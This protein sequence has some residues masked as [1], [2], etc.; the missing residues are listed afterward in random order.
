MQ[1]NKASLLLHPFFVG[2]LAVLL[3]NDCWGKYAFPGLLTG[4]LSDFVGLIVLP[5]FC[6][7]LFPSLSKK[8]I[9]L[10]VALFFIWFKSPLSQPLL[11][12]IN[13]FSYWPVNRVVDYSD[14]VA[15]CVLPLA[16]RIQPKTIRLQTTGFFFLRWALGAITFF[17]LCSTSVYRGLF[18]AHPAM[19]DV[20]FGESITIKRPAEEVLRNLEAKEIYYRRDSV[21]FYP[22]TNQDKLYYKTKADTDTA[23]TWQPVSMKMDST[24]YVRWEGVPY[25]FI[26]E[27]H[28][29]DRTIRNIRFTLSENR[30]KTKTTITI[31]MFQADGL[32]SYVAWDRKMKKEYKTIFARL[33]SIK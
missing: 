14:L 29:E 12:T 26:P 27:Y 13:Q 21:M 7:V 8:H 9:L 33:F 17:S 22:I 23:I 4:K 28:S 24:L 32:R 3:S 15:L 11:N 5:V 20:Y 18:Q 2:S 19:D 6:R 16:V 1:E 25:Y 10:T 30:K 31:Q